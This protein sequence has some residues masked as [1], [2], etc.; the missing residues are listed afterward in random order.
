MK[1]YMLLSSS[2]H[3]EGKEYLH[4]R[5]FQWLDSDNLLPYVMFFFISE[6]K[7]SI[8]IGNECIL[9]LRKPWTNIMKH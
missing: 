8:N 4:W 9:L 6:D 1:M 7:P 2:N 5:P 3:A